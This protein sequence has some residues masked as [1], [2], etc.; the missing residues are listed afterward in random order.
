MQL[1]IALQ[2]IVTQQLLPTA[3]GS[4]RVAACEVLVPTPAIRNLI[5]EG[6]THQIYSAIQT[7][8]AA[9]MQT[10]DADLAQLVRMGKITR[11]LCRAA[12]LGP[13]GA[14]A[15]DRRRRS[16]A[17]GCHRA[18]RG[19]GRRCG[20]GRDAAMSTFAFRAV[21]LAGVPSRGEV[22]A[23]LEGAGH[24]AAAPARPDRPRRLREARGAQARGR[25]PALQER[26]PARTWPVFSRQFA[27][28]IASG[29]ADAA[30][31]LHA[32]GADR[33]RDAQGG[34]RSRA[35]T[36]RPAARWRGGDGAPAQ[37]L[38]PLYRSMVRSARGRGGSR[39]PSTG[40]PP[41]REARRPAAPGQ[42][43][44]DVPGVVFALAMS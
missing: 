15:P 18:A 12:R 2:G 7:S 11:S 3:D 43:G 29:D 33:G 9:G 39:R 23:E 36:S 24:R 17:I 30:L 44:D 20:G 13:R 4:G 27:T 6:K 41:A 5:R 8:G 14:Q 16:P 42:V 34:D 19:A 32:R 22:E 28:L 25:L 21:D 35:R 37:G 10:M 40:S 31:A 1:S 26:Q 38:R